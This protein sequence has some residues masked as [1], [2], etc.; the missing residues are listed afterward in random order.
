MAKN[1]PHP[2]V[3]TVNTGHFFDST[4][5]FLLVFSMRVRGNTYKGVFRIYEGGVGGIGGG[6]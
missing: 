5:Q 4:S 6:D 1:V 2:A 3:Y